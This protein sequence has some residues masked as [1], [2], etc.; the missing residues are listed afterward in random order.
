MGMFIKV[1]FLTEGKSFFWAFKQRG[2]HRLSIA[3][4]LPN[5]LDDGVRV[6]SFMNVQG[7]C[8]HLKRGVFSLASP[9]QLR[10]K[11]RIVVQWLAPLFPWAVCTLDLVF[12]LSPP[13]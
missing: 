10:V 9:H 5:G 1:N 6:D 2:L 4:P 8:R 3:V 11:M 7:N 12:F 13:C